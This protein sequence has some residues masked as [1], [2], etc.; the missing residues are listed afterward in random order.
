MAARCFSSSA[1]L[2]RSCASSIRLFS[3]WLTRFMARAAGGAGTVEAYW[4]PPLLAAGGDI[5]VAWGS[6]PGIWNDGCICCGAVIIPPGPAMVG[7][8]G[9]SCWRDGLL[10]PLPAIGG[11]LVGSGSPLS[12]PRIRC[13]D[14]TNCCSFSFPSLPATRSQMLFSTPLSSPLFMKTGKHSPPATKPSRSVS[15]CAKAWRNLASACGFIPGGHATGPPG[16]APG[17]A[18]GVALVGGM[19]AGRA[20]CCICI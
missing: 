6:A 15:S 14:M 11:R 1:F 4:K 8:G 9:V 5:R 7:A 17:V 12:A 3:S 18:P 2:A 16:L 13:C 19:G 10:L 20:G